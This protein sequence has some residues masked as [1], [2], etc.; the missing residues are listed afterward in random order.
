MD[1]THEIDLIIEKIKDWEL[2]DIDELLSRIYQE[3]AR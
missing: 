3:K 2:P 1:I